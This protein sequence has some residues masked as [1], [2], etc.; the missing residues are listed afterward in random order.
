M[1]K[2]FIAEDEGNT[3]NGIIQIV[4]NY[5]PETVVSGHAKTV[6]DAVLFLSQ[7]S[8]DLALLDIN[9]PDGKGFDI[10]KN[11]NTINFKIIFITAFE[12]YALQA[13]KFSA[14]DYLLKPINPKELIEAVHKIQ[15]ERI[16]DSDTMVQLKTLLSNMN[17]KESGIKK[18]VLKTQERIHVINTSEIIRCESDGSYTTFFLVSEKKIIVS[19]SLS[20]YEEL[21]IDYNFLRV[22]KSHLVNIEYIESFEKSSGGYLVMKDKTQVPVSIRK[23]ELTI[24]ALDNL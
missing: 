16:I 5:I 20:E 23:K 11:L 21:L 8:I 18:I 13:I 7:N 3:L 22:H 12:K 1:L 4:K 17:D 24:R 10:L 15:K 2:I 6:S 9:F 14:S 19:K